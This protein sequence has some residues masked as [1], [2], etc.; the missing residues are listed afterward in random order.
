M[1][2]MA[3]S[4]LDQIRQQAGEGAGGFIVSCLACILDALYALMEQL[5]KFGI[6]RIAITGEDFWEG[7]RNATD[8]LARNLLSTVREGSG[9]EVVLGVGGWSGVFPKGVGFWKL[10]KSH[11]RLWVSCIMMILHGTLMGGVT[12]LMT[13]FKNSLSL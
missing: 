6:V 2:E 5:T 12:A 11:E 1:I 4:A 13:A 7:C 9:V 10:C 8:L 3:R